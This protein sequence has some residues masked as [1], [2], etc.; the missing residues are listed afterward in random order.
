MQQAQNDWEQISSERWT[1]R[2][3]RSLGDIRSALDWGLNAQ[4][5]QPLAIRLAA[6]STPLWQELSLLKEHGVYVRK[7]LALLEATHQPCPR[8]TITLKLALGSSCYHTLGSSAEAV[9][10]FVSAKHLAE[11]CNDVAGQL[12]AISGHLAVDLSCGH[13]QQALEQSRQF[14]RLGLHGDAV[15]ALSTQRLRVLALHFAGDQPLA[16]ENVEQ[17][18]QCL[19]QSGHL[20]RF[21]YCFGVHYDQSVA[22]LTILARI[23][24]LQGHPEKKPGAL[25]DRRSTSRC[26]SIMARPSAIP[27]RWPVA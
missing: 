14:E 19:A 2:Y 10:A 27:W 5:P 12:K 20:N 11:R 22:A 8:V 3:A 23:L 17:V 26:R 1:E 4:G 21:S 18:I 24:W 9:E 16:R 15:L 25:H 6:T 13:Y 7:A